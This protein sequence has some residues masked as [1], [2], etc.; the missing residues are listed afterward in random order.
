MEYAPERPTCGC[1]SQT[2]ERVTV[3]R[4]DGAPYPTEF[5]ACAHCQVMYH[6]PEVAR[7]SVHPE[8]PGADYWTGLY[9]KR[10]REK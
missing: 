4:S 5:V 3:T 6:R 1:G 9:R 10:G 2:F 7:S 8:G